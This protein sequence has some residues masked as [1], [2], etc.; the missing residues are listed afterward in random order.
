MYFNKNKVGA[1]MSEHY[2][3]EKPQSKSKPKTWDYSLR[4][5]VYTFTSDIGVFSKN[6]VDFGTRLLIESFEE[7]RIQGHI[8][9]MGCGYG[10]IGITLA[11]S[12]PERHRSEEHTSELQ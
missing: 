4:G 12:F 5:N 1:G 9:D 8:L 3:S 7:P 6:E 2:F 10:P 11:H